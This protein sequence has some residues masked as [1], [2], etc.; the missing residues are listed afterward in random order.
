MTIGVI[1]FSSIVLVIA[2]YNLEQQIV[3]VEYEREELAE[4]LKQALSQIPNAIADANLITR[5][6]REKSVLRKKAQVRD[7]LYQDRIGKGENFT[8]LVE[9]LAKQTVDGIWLSKFEVLNKGEDIQLYGYAKTPKQVSKYIEMLG[10]QESYQGR[11]FQQIEIKRTE[12]R[13]NEFYISTL[14]K[15][16]VREIETSLVV[17]EER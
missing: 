15:N 2:K 12:R 9:Q 6:D 17:E 5:I 3:G 10:N 13:W 8:G 4:A 11:N 14:T 1:V 7:Y 16:D